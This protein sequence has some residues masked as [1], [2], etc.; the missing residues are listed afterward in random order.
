MNRCGLSDLR[1]RGT[2]PR[3]RQARRDFFIPAASSLA[4]KFRSRDS[5]TL[6]IFSID[7]WSLTPA[8]IASRR[9][10][11]VYRFRFETYVAGSG[12]VT[13]YWPGMILRRRRAS[14]EARRGRT[15]L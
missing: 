10:T 14:E 11:R 5:T 2:L 13:V 15:G 4:R 9:S 3:A 7:P 8:A 12:L 6:S 1:S